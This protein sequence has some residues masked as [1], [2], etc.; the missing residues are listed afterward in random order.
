MRSQAMWE[1]HPNSMGTVSPQD[2]AAEA[3]LTDQ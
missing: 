2:Y 3:E 1:S